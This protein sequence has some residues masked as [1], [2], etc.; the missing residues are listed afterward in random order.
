MSGAVNRHC[1]PG[2]TMSRP[3]RGTSLQECPGI[4]KTMH[5]GFGA[6]VLHYANT[7]CWHGR[8]RTMHDFARGKICVVFWMLSCVVSGR[9]DNIFCCSWI[10]CNPSENSCFSKIFLC[11]AEMWF[12]LIST[13]HRTFS[14]RCV[15]LENLTF[16]AFTVLLLTR[17]YRFLTRCEY[18]L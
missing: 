2:L 5:T 1:I 18:Y 17:C 7:I 8:N 9:Y 3:W 10:C 15:F 16:T 6:Y 4:I 12:L 11:I 13:Y 14:I